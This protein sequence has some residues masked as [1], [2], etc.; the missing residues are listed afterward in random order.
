MKEREIPQRELRN[1]ISRIL[2]EVELGARF[3]VTVGGRLVAEL[4]PVSTRRTWVP[5]SDVERIREGAP[6]DPAFV[7]D[8]DELLGQ[9]IDEL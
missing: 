4:V 9:T 2:R 7:S 5:W 6:L 1:H 3:R 8:A